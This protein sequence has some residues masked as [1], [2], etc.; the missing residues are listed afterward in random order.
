[1]RGIPILC[2]CLAALAI[3]PLLR[4]L[5]D[6]VATD[7]STVLRMDLDAQV[8]ASALVVEGTVL[9]VQP[10][11]GLGG[12][13]VTDYEIAVDRTFLGEDL[14]I[15]TIRMPGGSHP[16]G[17][18]TMVPGVPTL[19][20]GEDVLL[21]LT[22]TGTNELRLP[23]GLS[24]GKYRLESSPGRPRRAVRDHGEV[25]W[26]EANGDVHRGAGSE[27]VS[28]ADLSARLQ[29]SIA[30]RAIRVAQRAQEESR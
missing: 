16:S 11:R 19:S 10:L 27:A 25:L 13:V 2:G 8:D 18:V 29:A 5:G 22:E 6:P 30:G 12:H 3:T 23:V 9:S 20:V 1:M 24:Q 7:A 26:V 28:Y 14:P 17:I 4:T 15:R 21:L